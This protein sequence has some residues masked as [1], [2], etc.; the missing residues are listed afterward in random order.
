MKLRPLSD[1]L[2][3]EPVMK[4]EA[5]RSGIVLPDTA[6]KERSE[7]GVVIA[8]GPGRTFEGK[9]EP[10]TVKVGEKIL[11][12]K[13]GPDEI[14]IDGKELMVLSETDVLAVIE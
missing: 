13:Y 5:T 8:V 14:K 6:G 3:I 12:K 4:E 11:F 7:Q 10:M 9:L 1:H 2:V